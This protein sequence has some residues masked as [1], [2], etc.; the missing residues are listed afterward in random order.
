MQCCSGPFLMLPP[1]T[2]CIGTHTRAVDGHTSRGQVSSGPCQHATDQRKGTPPPSK[3]GSTFLISMCTCFAD[4]SALDGLHARSEGSWGT[5]TASYATG[6]LG[7]V[8]GLAAPLTLS[9]IIAHQPLSSCTKRHSNTYINGCLFDW[10]NDPRWCYDTK[11][12][13]PYDQASN[14]LLERRC[15]RSPDTSRV[16]ENMKYTSD[17]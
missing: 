6:S 9:C 4:F 14:T 8:R 13:R 16:G 2:P 5:A 12:Y 15:V 10:A 17:F 7:V 1:P 11:R 3:E